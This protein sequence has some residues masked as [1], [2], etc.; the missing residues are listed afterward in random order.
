ME[1]YWNFQP[2]NFKIITSSNFA[3]LPSPLPK[4]NKKHSTQTHLAATMVEKRDDA[5]EAS[6][7]NFY[8]KNMGP[9]I[10]CP[11]ILPGYPSSSY[12]HPVHLMPAEITVLFRPWLSWSNRDFRSRK[13]PKSAFRLDFAIV[14]RMQLFRPSILDKVDRSQGTPHSVFDEKILRYFKI[15]HHK[16]A[17]FSV[18]IYPFHKLLVVKK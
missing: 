18:L 11:T 8:H 1:T 17:D 6:S 9:W 10:A 7:P 16:S 4:T 2:W 5:G 13:I 12:N 15:N 3:I 14:A